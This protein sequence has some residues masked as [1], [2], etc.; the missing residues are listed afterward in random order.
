MTRKRSIKFLVLLM[1]M[2]LSACGKKEEPKQAY[3]VSVNYINMI[4]QK[5]TTA[6]AERTV[7]TEKLLDTLHDALEL[8]YEWQDGQVVYRSIRGFDLS[9]CRVQVIKTEEDR[10][11]EITTSQMSTY[12][13]N[14]QKVNRITFSVTEE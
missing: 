10:R 13:L 1:I 3:N 5:Q 9:G 6:L 14:P 7:T 11:F 4:D 12:T 2:G 8:E